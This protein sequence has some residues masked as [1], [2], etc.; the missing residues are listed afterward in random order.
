MFH[1][2][3]PVH[4]DLTGAR[5]KPKLLQT[6]TFG[7]VSTGTDLFHRKQPENKASSAKKRPVPL[8]VLLAVPLSPSFR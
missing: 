1:A 8:T 3:R 4:W 6:Q 2:H 7:E 5:K